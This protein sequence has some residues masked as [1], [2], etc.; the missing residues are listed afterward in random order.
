MNT[1]ITRRQMMKTAIAATVVAGYSTGTFRP[2]NAQSRAKQGLALCLGL[3]NVDS[4]A[5]GGYVT[6]LG[7]CVND[8]KKMAAIAQ[9]KGF[10][11]VIALRQ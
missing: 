1:P 3:N 11:Q 10:D 7:G 6:P 2:L 9:S 8:M 4:R 5:Y